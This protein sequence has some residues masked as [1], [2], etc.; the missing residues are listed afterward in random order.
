[1]LLSFV[2]VQRLCQTDVS[3]TSHFK[4]IWYW[5]LSRVCHLNKKTQ[6]IYYGLHSNSDHT[7]DFNSHTYSNTLYKETHIFTLFVKY[8][9]I[10][11]CLRCYQAFC[12]FCDLF[13]LAFLILDWYL[14]GDIVLCLYCVILFVDRLTSACWFLDSLACGRF[15]KAAL[16]ADASVL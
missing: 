6:T 3:V 12:I 11:C 8:T 15:K 13:S 10:P 14:F 7:L 5:R 4:F 16:S 9:L 1:V 2:V